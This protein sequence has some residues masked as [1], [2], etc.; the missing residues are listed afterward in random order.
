M[1]QVGGGGRHSSVRVVFVEYRQQC[2]CTITAPLPRVTGVGCPYTCPRSRV[3][4]CRC[5]GRNSSLPGGIARALLTSRRTLQRCYTSFMKHQSWPTVMASVV[6]T[7]PSRR[8]RQLSYVIANHLPNI[9]TA[10]PTLPIRERN[11][12]EITWEISAKLVS[13]RKHAD[14]E[15]RRLS[16]WIGDL[17][18]IWKKIPAAGTRHSQIRTHRTRI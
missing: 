11:S 18:T 10:L 3:I 17:T 15:P 6:T 14:S 1:T 13:N 8:I 9:N 2:S 4:R 5:W 7:T 12:R 16:T